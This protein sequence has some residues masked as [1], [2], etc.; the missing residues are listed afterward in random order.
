M[1]DIHH[2]AVHAPATES[3]LDPA[4]ARDLASLV[5]R[6]LSNNSSD[7]PL[8]VEMVSQRTGAMQTRKQRVA[9]SRQ[10]S[11]IIFAAHN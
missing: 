9:P 11:V 3:R 10:L 5:S 2:A 8:T 1:Y 7:S 6:R 4:R